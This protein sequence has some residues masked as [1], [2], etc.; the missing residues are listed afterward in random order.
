MNAAALLLALAG[1]SQNV[2]PI[3]S[4]AP[5]V[6][7]VR[8][9]T[10]IVVDGLLSEEV[11]ATAPAVTTFT[12]RDPTEGAAPSEKTEVR[13]A[14]DDEAI[15]VGAR[16]LDSQPRTIV[17][18]LGRRDSNLGADE[19]T[20]YVDPYHDGRSGYYFAV[21]AAG[22]LRDGVLY[23][24]DW[25][26][27][28]WDGI[29]EGRAHVDGEGWT[30]EMRIPYSQLRFRRED[31]NAW[32]VNFRRYVCRTKEE[33]YV[34]YTP[35]KAS[36]FVSRFPKLSG[37]QGIVPPRRI[38]VTPYTT[39][40][41]EFTGHDAGDP[42]N[43]GSRVRPAMG[44]DFKVGLG[45]NLTID[46]TINPDFGQVE[47]DPAVVNLSDVETFF[48]EKRPFFVEGA[49]N[50]RFGQGG[51][52]N[53]WGFNWGGPDLFY[54]RRIGRAPE[55]SLPDAD[56]SDSPAGTRIVMASKLTGRL[57]HGWSLGALHAVTASETADLAQG[58]RRFR[59]HVE[60]TSQYVV[61]RALR[62]S[63]DN[64][65]G[66][67][68][69]ATGV[70]RD[71]GG[72]RLR[73]E[74]NA[75]AFTLG[76]DGWAFLGA[77]KTWVV[78]GWAAATDVAGTAA[79]LTD[80]QQDAQHYFQRPDATHVRLDPTRTSLRG[81]A[82]RAT[83]NKEKGNFLLNAAVG[84]ID[85]GFDVSDVGFQWRTDVIN[86]HLWT[87]YRWTKA[88]RLTREADVG[89]AYFRSYDFGGNVTWQG[90]FA[91]GSAR[92]K[93]ELR[94]FGFVAYNPDTLSSTRT[95]G[96]P[97]SRNPHG[98]EWDS[99]IRSDDRCKVSARFGLHGSDY[100]ER[101]GNGRWLFA[102][103]T[104]RP[105]S[106]I[107]VSFEPEMSWTHNG[108]QYLNTFDDP[109]ATATY[110][111]RYVFAPLDQ[112]TFVGGLRL[113]WTFTPRLSLELYAQPLLSSGDYAAPGELSAPRTYSF[114][115]YGADGST[116][117]AATGDVDPDGPGPAPAFNVGTPDFNF[118]SLRGNLVLRWEFR[119]G[120]T[121]YAVWT[122]SRSDQQDGVGEFAFRRSV[123]RLF[124]ARGDN[125]FLVKVTYTWNR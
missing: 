62:E 111:H 12:Q 115:T 68:V 7:A 104:V 33:D 67:G 2:Q 123:S 1:A 73:D 120:S 118:K 15:Y 105:R 66:L 114:R 58:G 83:V 22:T 71:L 74:L 119:P 77:N 36:G 37:L 41:A 85:P 75:H 31:S 32:G 61:A 79:R 47:V 13:I 80:L 99:S 23:N 18:R 57:G 11:W 82:G 117:D 43:D 21:N 46:G 42:F 25:N 19:L 6:H 65:R 125:I 84:A 107:L 60:P 45:S 27:D 17:G 53:W 64:R 110:G 102:G 112:T 38:A 48:P 20:F 116:Y 24:D 52:T 8:T 109:L 30:V 98:I 49:N 95:R 63:P 51:A 50:F 59:A 40:R 108:A 106:N 87:G 10:P 29:W 28:S 93:N 113:N 72:G 55:G 9:T 5:P 122:Q 81:F 26:D 14:Y 92:L 76:L 90:L 97:L 16:L 121:A 103:L 89:L 124:D 94:L 44:A 91:H 54:S 3:E 101:S 96:G 88:G 78:T 100:A 86:S 4:L 39:T 69:M 70:V 56:F 34:A 35:K